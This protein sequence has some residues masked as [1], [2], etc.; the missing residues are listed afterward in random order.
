MKTINNHIKK[1]FIVFCFLGLIYACGANRSDAQR[2]GQ[3]SLGM[4]KKEALTVMQHNPD[5]FSAIA[6]T[7]YLFYREGMSEYFIRLIDGKVE[8]Y[9][10]VGDFGT[11]KNPT[12]DM[13]LNLKQKQ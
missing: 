11:T 1:I 4:T 12:L 2:M 13:N 9:G 10:R 8:A 5:R 6:N 3:L 7:E